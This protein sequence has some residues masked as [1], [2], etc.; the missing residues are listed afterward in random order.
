M[1]YRGGK[2]AKLLTRGAQ[3]RHWGI[4]QSFYDA[5]CKYLLRQPE[6]MFLYGKYMLEY[7]G[8][9]GCGFNTRHFKNWVFHESQHGKFIAKYEK[10][11]HPIPSSAIEQ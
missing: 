11:W 4:P 9:S 3:R 5:T 7:A 10:D 1:S 8:I 6:P 2:D